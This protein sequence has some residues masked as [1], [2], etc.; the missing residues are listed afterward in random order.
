LR[1][2][3][4]EIINSTLALAKEEGLLTSPELPSVIVELPKR[5][6]FGDYSTNVAMLLA[7]GEKR[8]P[9][10]IAEQI[11]GLLSEEPSIDKCEVAGPGFIN[12][13]L[14]NS[15]WSN[16]LIEILSKGTGYGR[17]DVGKGL[18]VQVEFVS[19]NPTGPLHI[20]HGR[21]AAVGDSL[22]N[23]LK[24]AGYE[25]TKEYYVNDVGRQVYNLGTSVE[26]RAKELDG[27]AIELGDDHYKGDYIIDIASKFKESGSS[28]SAKEFAIDS[29]LEMIDEALKD[30]NVGFDLWFKESSLDEDGRIMSAID[31]LRENGKVYDKD[32]AVWL[33]T[34]ELGDDKDRVLIKAD[35]EKTYFAS[36]IAYHRDKFERGFDRVV[37]IWGA[38]H[39]GYEARVRAALKAFGFDD[40]K[41]S[42]L[43]I[44][45]VSLLRDGEPVAMGKRSGEFVTLKDVMDEVGSDACRFFFLM[46][47]PDAQLDFDL[48]LA[49]R[50]AP[51]NPVY[52]VQY[53]HARICSIIEHAKEQGIELPEKIDP[54][55]IGKLT[56]K[57]ALVI[58]KH[59]AGFVEVVEASAAS[60]EPHRV[61][62]YLQQLAGLF[63][64]YYNKNRVV[65]DDK[66][67]TLARLYLCTAI[68]TVA[69][70]GLKLLGVSAPDKM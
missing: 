3:V 43:F 66:D 36:D 27:E 19:A 31:E 11:S 58:I 15:Y 68:K 63:H 61:N 42:V 70:V 50:H 26:L 4:A 53:C 52:Y 20:G 37:N 64:P 40:E 60:M 2:R 16:L 48:E 22:A 30:F 57:D 14:K 17:S 39:H 46:R 65:T 35:G 18:R 67:E 5:P 8:P 28:K 6:E 12:I 55:I 34:E 69:E 62:Y 1:A 32:G 44:Q 21:G 54:E 49:K 29:M 13:F 23:I 24:L 56:G 7:P 38:D 25:V 9:R 47:K 45:M 51:E 59:L 10:E 41:L 33:K